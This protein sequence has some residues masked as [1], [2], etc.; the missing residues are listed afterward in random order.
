MSV[1]SPVNI[2]SYSS[3][4]STQI[5]AQHASHTGRTTPLSCFPVSPLTAENALP[6][7]IEIPETMEGVLKAFDKDF[8]H[9]LNYGIGGTIRGALSDDI[10]SDEDISTSL[11]RET[12][13][14]Y[15]YTQGSKILPGWEMQEITPSTY[16]NYRLT[17]VL[18]KR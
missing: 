12:V 7:E 13:Q 4:R 6:K 16:L 17:V 15:F 18:K 8:P 3:P 11:N 5:S 2:Q 10:T 9:S 1:A 14:K